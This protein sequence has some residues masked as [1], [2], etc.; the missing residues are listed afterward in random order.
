MSKLTLNIS[1]TFLIGK[2]NIMNKSLFF[3]FML[4]IGNSFLYSLLSKKFELNNISIYVN[5]EYVQNSKI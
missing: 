4:L 2:Y 3:I 5:I 1:I